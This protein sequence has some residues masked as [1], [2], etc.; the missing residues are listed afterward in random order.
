METT[1]N[2]HSAYQTD[3]NK[4]ITFLEHDTTDVEVLNKAQAK[5]DKLAA[6]YQD[7][8]S[9]GVERYMLYQAQAM[10]SYRLGET[11]KARQFIDE[12]I[13]VRGES[14]DLAEQLLAHLDEG[15]VPKPTTRWV[16]LMA[17]PVPLLVLIALAQFVVHFVLAKTDTTAGVA[18]TTSLATMT[19]NIFSL[20]G[21][22]AAVITLLLIPVWV[23]Q[24]IKARRYNLQHGYALKKKN[25]VIVAVF[26]GLWYWLYTYERNKTKFW[27][28]FALSIVSAGYWGIIAW[29]WAIVD[30]ST[31]PD[32]YYEQY[33][34]YDA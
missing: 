3:V 13:N 22:V 24:L 27:V 8:E 14:Y 34:N 6:Q 23:I 12:A 2:K 30:A 32:E 28:N 17:M 15:F 29:I 26:L 10:L 18:G 33:P 20:L 19:V 5:L 16:V 25:A 11:A 9:I 7:D 31:K 1:N 21:G 4:I